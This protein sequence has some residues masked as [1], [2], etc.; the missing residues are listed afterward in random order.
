[1]STST[2]LSLKIPVLDLSYEQR[3]RP[4]HYVYNSPRSAASIIDFDY[5]RPVRRRKEIHETF[6]AKELGFQA[7]SGPDQIREID[8]STE[9]IRKFLEL[10]KW[11]KEEKRAAVIFHP[12]FSIKKDT[13][14]EVS[15][16]LLETLDMLKECSLQN[17][18]LLEEKQKLEAE[19][20]LHK[21]Q[22]ELLLAENAH[23]RSQ[24]ENGSSSGQSKCKGSNYSTN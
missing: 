17:R 20:A 5:D 6:V 7:P 21:Q 24:K 19:V 8:T 15:G 9:K 23:L 4:S 12:F 11:T 2:E 1:M 13:L 18:A 3:V 16:P 22:V 10:T 14:E